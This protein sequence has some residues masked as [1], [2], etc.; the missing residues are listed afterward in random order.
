MSGAAPGKGTTKSSSPL[1][2]QLALGVLALNLL[3][4]G[5]V[6][7]SSYKSKEQCEE[8][9]RITSQNLS[10]VLEQYVTGV[11]SR[12]DA[13]VLAAAMEA[14]REMAHGGIDAQ[15]LD[16]YIKRQQMELSD[17][18]SLVVTDANGN[19]LNGVGRA[20]ARSVSAADR[21][22]FTRMRQDPLVKTTVSRPFKSRISGKWVIAVARRIEKPDGSFGG[23]ATASFPFEKFYRIF[24][25]IDVGRHGSITLRDQQLRL[26][27]RYPELPG[28]GNPVGGEA[29]AEL[30]RLVQNGGE[31]GTYRARSLMDQ[32]ER[33]FSFRKI[34]GRPYYL[35]VGLATDDYLAAWRSNSLQVGILAVLFCLVTTFSAGLLSREWRRRNAALEELIRQETKYQTIADHTYAWEFWL[36]P[37]ETFIYSSP[38]CKRITGYAPAA[39]YADAALLKNIVHPE[40]QQCFCNHRHQVLSDTVAHN[41]VMRIRHADGSVRWMEHEC[42]PVY[43]E[44]GVFLGTRG[45]NRDVTSRKRME[46]ALKE[47]EEQFHQLFVQN[48]DAVM[49]LHQENFAVLD[50]NP[51]MVSLFGYPL[52]E[53]RDFGPYALSA[54]EALWQFQA[55]LQDAVLHGESYLD[56]AIGNC[57]GGAEI[58]LSAKTKLIR[59][60]EENVL[61][62]SFRDIS[63]RMRLEK[64]KAE[65]QSKLIHANKMTSLGMLVS[66]IAHEINNPNQYISLNASIL[67]DVWQDAYEILSRHHEEH[68][69]LSLKGM[70]L[71][72]AKETVPRLL[73]GVTE[74]A[75]RINLIVADL[76]D[77]SRDKSGQPQSNFD[78]NKVVQSAV[79]I[80]THHI[81]KHTYHFQLE[82]ADDIP[83][84]KGKSQQIEQVVINLIANGLQALVD[85]SKAVRVATWHERETDR[86]VLTVSDQGKGMTKEILQRITEPFFST[87][88]GEGGTG[89][90]LSISATL[91][92]EHGGTLEFVSEPDLGTTA[93]IKLQA[94]RENDNG[95]GCAAPFVESK[96]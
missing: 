94:A 51:A 27:V 72:Q 83:G 21:D 67:A 37:D 65:V 47:S 96:P 9:A 34:S 19:F 18:E 70:S 90:G 43:D 42:L 85:K 52:E 66:G 23:M 30:H 41:L 20:P 92:K 26:A 80:L 16:R 74:G 4:V 15:A 62:C 2:K 63:D 55:L 82:L 33:C 79:Q 12:L 8:Q 22:H 1:A 60:R 5:L 54:P 58:A 53:L 31:A 49:L 44:S 39:F 57:K 75:R 78:L 7:L 86:V 45:S 46:E 28:F 95:P 48:W 77:F 29:T 93:T 14:E 84:V 88:L 36:S 91:L 81:H 10:Q 73:T 32:G 40:D 69:E 59:L 6:G 71:A 17:L 13:G 61:Y 35:I 38:S 87:K 11:F 64:E 56:R 76:K 89:L 24:S 50:A 3:I 25:A 68:G